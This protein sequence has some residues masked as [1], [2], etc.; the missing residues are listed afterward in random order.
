MKITLVGRGRLATNL[1]PALREA[2]HEV[3]QMNSRRIEPQPWGDLYI[4]AV[5]DSALRE[6]AENVR[7]TFDGLLVH[8]AGSMPLDTL[9]GE[10]RA[11]LYPMQTFSKERRVSFRHIPL[12][13]EAETND[14]L[15]LVKALASSLSTA[16]YPLAGEQRRRLHLAAVFACNFTNHMYALSADI[17]AEAGLPFEVMLP[18][19]D[20]TA[21]KVHALAPREAQTGPAVRW[22]ENVIAAQTR[23]AGPRATLYKVISESIHDQLRPE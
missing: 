15:A 16:V 23:L 4:L 22:D 12:F 13:I 18:L 5:K 3:R 20:E 17:L 9:P 6:V 7:K 21:A 2:G 8:T 19:I 1:L 10:R 14:D 11:V